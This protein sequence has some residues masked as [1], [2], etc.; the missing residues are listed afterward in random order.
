MIEN[1]YKPYLMTIAEIIDEAPGVRTLRL[2]FQDE[3]EGKNFKFSSGQFALY[4]AFGYGEATFC[5]ASPPTRSE[6]IECTF[7]QAGRVTNA[8]RELNVG[9]TVGLRGP[10]GNT[11]PIEEWEGKNL[12]FVAG[13]IALPPLRCV[14]DNC[15]DL[16]DKYGKITIVYGA[17]TVDDLVYKKELDEW[18]N[19]DDIDTIL[20]VDP[21]GE[22]ESWHGKVGFVPTVLEEAAPDSNNTVALVCGP[23]IM[24][25]FTL[26]VLEKLGFSPANIFTTL[27]NRMK[28]GFGKCGRCNVGGVYVCKDGPVFTAEQLNSMPDEY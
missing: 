14:I 6:F 11:F 10:Y 1:I 21:G 22:N 23:P 15:I 27:E 26:P 8:L 2:Q 19:R 5:I 3:N 20:T 13:G 28:C 16:R 4:S 9:D 12:V 7:R 17:K 18:S 25:K 24:I